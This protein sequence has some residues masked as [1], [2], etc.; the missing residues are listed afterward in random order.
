[1]ETTIT[2]PKPRG[3]EHSEDG[4]KRQPTDSVGSGK[5]SSTKGALDL[6]PDVPMTH[7]PAPA[8]VHSSLRRA[9]RL[10]GGAWR[11][12]RDFPPLRHGGRD[13][14]DETPTSNCSP[15]FDPARSRTPGF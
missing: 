6:E 12:P 10:G 3:H 7:D 11:A 5:S 2:T 4:M 9:Q 14:W 13:S 15:D 8:P 1:M